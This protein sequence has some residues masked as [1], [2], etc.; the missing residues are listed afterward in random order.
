MCGAVF[1]RSARSESASKTSPNSMILE[2]TKPAVNQLRA[3]RGSAPGEIALLDE[4]DLE[5][6]ARGI[7]RDAK[8][9]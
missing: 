2:I 9:P 7:A 4:R 5:P 8:R 6:A 1:R 3:S